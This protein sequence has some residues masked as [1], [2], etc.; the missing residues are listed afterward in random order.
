MHKKIKTP[1]IILGGFLITSEA[2]SITKNTIENISGRKVYIVNVTRRDWFRSIS[3][4]GWI[5]ILNKVKNKV[6][7]AL[8]ET[9]AKKIDL[10]GHS[11]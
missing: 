4:E 5:K 9:K 3:A 10:I 1:I 2:Y 8:K 6:A 11:S 7:F